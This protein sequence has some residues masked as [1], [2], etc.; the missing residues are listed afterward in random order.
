LL[1]VDE[2]VMIHKQTLQIKIIDFGSAMPLSEKPTS[3]FYGTQ[4]FSCPEA[5]GGNEYVPTKQEVWA[6]G[7]LLY[8]LLFKMDP[9]GDDD[10]IIDLDIEKR[11]SRLR[12]S[13]FKGKISNDAVDAIVY[14]LD[15]DPAQRPNIDEV[16]ELPFF[17]SN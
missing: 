5:L 11:V 12:R 10:E 3:I 6:L 7:T 2:N 9:F 17:D 13:A 15:K 8:V 1:I 4:K 14:M 16:L